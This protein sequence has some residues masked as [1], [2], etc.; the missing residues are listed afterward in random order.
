MSVFK[1]I[2][3]VFR[4]NVNDMISKAED[5]EK[6]LTQLT[7]DMRQQ[8]TQAKQ[9]VASAMADERRLHQQLTAE[10]GQAEEWE[11]KAM[12]A[13]RAGRDD[14]AGQALQRKTDHDKVVTGYQEQWEAQ[15]AS[16]DQLKE[17]L[18]RLQSKI[19]EAQRKKNLLIARAKRAEAQKKIAQTM[20]GLS[21]SSAFDTF[22]RMA[23]KVEQVE[24]TADASTQ[25]QAELEGTDLDSEIK[26]LEAPT[27]DAALLALKQRMG[28]LPKPEDAGSPQLTDDKPPSS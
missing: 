2:S 20:G 4:A 3:T 22:D 11:H 9:Q 10:Q 21:D 28:M 26:S 17:A 15:K 27:D 16:V 12:T 24:A 1:R 6:M 19:D 5:P 8:Y 18:R 25:L 14:L 23:A 13:V 7:E